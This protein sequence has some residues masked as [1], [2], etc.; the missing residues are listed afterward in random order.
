M[1]NEEIKKEEQ[2]NIVSYEEF[3]K[4]EMKVG[5]ILSVEIVPDADKLYKFMVDVGGESPRQI[6]SAIRDYYGEPEFFVNKKLVF[7]INLAPRTIRGFESQ[8]M[9][10]AVD[11][12]EGEPV[13]LVPE[14][15]V[16]PGSAVR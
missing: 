12:L 7:V 15:D 14:S 4:V 10:L 9:V 11:G 1:E 5:K 16:N 8:G 3:K 13:F 6:L 2:K